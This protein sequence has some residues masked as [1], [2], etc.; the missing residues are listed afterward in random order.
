MTGD[1]WVSFYYIH[2]LC[3]CGENRGLLIE[4][5]TGSPGRA[6]VLASNVFGG[7]FVPREYFDVS[8][9]FIAVAFPKQPHP[10]SE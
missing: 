8:Y 2:S 10:S 3:L 5:K 6:K 7:F 9:S 4:E 1:V